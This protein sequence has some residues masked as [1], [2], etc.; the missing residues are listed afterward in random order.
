[1][2]RLLLA[3]VALTALAAPA[4][5]F[6]ADQ[7]QSDLDTLRDAQEQY[8]F[9]ARNGAD[10]DTLQN[11]QNDVEDAQQQLQSDTDD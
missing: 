10:A 5:A 4:L 6:D 7:T 8:N 2:K 11:D 9:D 3:A 1:M